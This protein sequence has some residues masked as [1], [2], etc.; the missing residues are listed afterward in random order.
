MYLA[1]IAVY[2]VLAVAGCWLFVVVKKRIGK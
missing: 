2:V 1:Y